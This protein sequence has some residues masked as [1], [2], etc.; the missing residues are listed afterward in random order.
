MAGIHGRI[1]EIRTYLK[2][3]QR[4]FAKR[5]Y[6]SQSLYGEIE[7][8]HRDVK[9]RIIQLIATQF[10]VNKEWLKTGNGEMFTSPP[11]DL[12]RERL[13]EVFDALDEALQDYLLM[14][15]KELLRIQ[16]GKEKK[17]G[18]AP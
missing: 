11:P 6:I 4:E 17:D 7:L 5:I 15:S 10:N 12:R 18:L 14:Q 1:K 2:I 3:S 16:R 8:G 9:E 13:L